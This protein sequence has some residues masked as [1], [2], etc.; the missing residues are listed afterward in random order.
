MNNTAENIPPQNGSREEMTPDKAVV[1][2]HEEHKKGNHKLAQHV[3]NQ[4]LTQLPDFPPALRLQILL[5]EDMN[6]YD[7]SIPIYKKLSENNEL[8]NR[9][10]EKYAFALHREKHNEEAVD[11]LLE[12]EYADPGSYGLYNTLGLS[13]MNLGDYKR[14]R[15]AFR[16]AF[17]LEPRNGETYNNMG[18]LSRYTHE[19]HLTTRYFEMG[20]RI[21][22]DS[23]LAQTNLAFHYLLAGEYRKAWVF[24]RDKPQNWNKLY[25]MR[26]FT[27]PMWEGQDLVGKKILILPDQGFGDTLQMIRFIRMLKLQGAHTIFV[28]HKALKRLFSTYA[29]VDEFIDELEDAEDYDY[30]TLMFNMPAQFDISIDTIPEPEGGYIIPSDDIVKKWAK[31]FKK[32]KKS[33]SKKL[34]SKLRVG[35]VW[36]GNPFHSNDHERS[37]PLEKICEFLNIPDIDFYSLQFGPGRD[38]SLEPLKDKK[39]STLI[40]LMDNVKDFADTASIIHHLDLVITVDTA[41]AHLTGAMGIPCWVMI[42]QP[43]DWRWHMGRADCPWYDSLKLYRQSKTFFWDDIVDNIR[44]D[45][46]DFANQYHTDNGNSC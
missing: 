40:D 1:F 43:P 21:N 28:V 26:E 11:Q 23:D 13:Y 6:R 33:A 29:Y 30:Y 35:L 25:R 38:I 2:A 36:S 20:L 39:Y 16:T 12:V 34:M 22:P 37:M 14:A 18:G 31:H 24:Y 45:L 15:N 41:V 3:V 7:Q 4:I 44:H 17:A 42:T 10:R 27:S 32:T 5:L 46:I 9:Y 19:Y 8:D